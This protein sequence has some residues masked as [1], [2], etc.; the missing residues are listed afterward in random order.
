MEML[1]K[2][3]YNCFAKLDDAVSFVETYAIKMTEW[4]WKTRTN[5]LRKRRKKNEKSYTRSPK[6]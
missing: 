1:D 5:I 6:S 2:F 4:C 3:I